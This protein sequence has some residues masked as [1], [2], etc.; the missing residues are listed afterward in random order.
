[1]NPV[2]FEL[3]RG[4]VLE[5][6][7]RGRYA[8]VAG[9]RVIARKGDADDVTFLRSAAKPFQAITVVETGAR[10]AYG[11][12]DEEVAVVCGSHHGE[13]VHV[14][15]AGSILRK[16]GLKPA[17]LR[18]GVHAPIS[19]DAQRALARAGR[20]PT[21]LHNNCSGKHA[22]MV[23]AAKRLKAPLD[24]YLDPG[25]PLQ[26]R[27]LETI[28][29]FAD[30]KPSS[31]RLGVDGCSAPTFGMPLTAIAR[32]F[33]RLADPFGADY[34]FDVPNAMM[35]HPHMVGHPCEELMKAVPLEIV[36]KVGAEGVYGAC[37]MGHAV[38]IA[39]KIDDGNARALLAVVVALLG[40]LGLFDRTKR[41]ALEAIVRTEQKNHAGKVVGRLRATV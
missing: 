3:W 11:L 9:R 38:G 21:V 22:G 29:R 2:L 30:V 18:C 37:V 41:A 14:R 20:K 39:V 12:T 34:E 6:V 7:H 1:M 40:R 16:A 28:A 4:N 19:A 32:A 27:N 33:A 31:I 15:A 13:D 35:R 10:D 17:H 24:R 26:R 5:S 8:V 25:H 36:G 23:A